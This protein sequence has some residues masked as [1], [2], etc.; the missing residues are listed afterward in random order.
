MSHDKW[1]RTESSVEAWTPDEVR[2]QKINFIPPEFVEAV[3]ELLTKKWTGR[4]ATI[5][6]TDLK[7][8]VAHK[9]RTNGSPNLGKNYA[10]EGWLDFEPIFE[11]K[12]WK[13]VYDRP[14]WDESYDPNWTFTRK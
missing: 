1:S 4:S 3:N 9:M 14:G 6:L 12:G 5:R 8:L 2:A 7:Q 10:D 13:V 11:D